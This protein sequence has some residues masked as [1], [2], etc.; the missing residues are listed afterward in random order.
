MLP[1]VFALLLCMGVCRQAEASAG[2]QG[3]GGDGRKPPRLPCARIPARGAF[4]PGRENCFRFA[5]PS[6]GLMARKC[7]IALYGGRAEHHVRPA[8]WPKARRP[9]AS[10]LMKAAQRP[11][12]RCAMA[13]RKAQPCLPCN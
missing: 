2:G 13:K 8:A 11:G 3:D 4:V 12:E 9:W 10:V 1:G 7:P 6:A 5:C